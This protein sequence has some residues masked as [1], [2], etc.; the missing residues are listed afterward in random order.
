[1]NKK[2]YILLFCLSGSIS[3][4]YKQQ[5]FCQNPPTTHAKILCKKQPK[6]VEKA[7][8]ELPPLQPRP[9]KTQ[10]ATPQ[11]T[12][13]KSLKPSSTHQAPRT[14]QPEFTYKPYVPGGYKSPEQEKK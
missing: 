5:Q 3:F 9:V 10:R 13:P 14:I 8:I 12:A 7:S 6:K 4:A 11:N 2:V 1:M